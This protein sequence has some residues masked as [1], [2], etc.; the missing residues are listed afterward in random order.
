MDN[1]YRKYIKSVTNLINC[2]V[3]L[4]KK[5]ETDLYDTLL[6]KHAETGIEDPVLLMGE[7]EKIAEEFMENLGITNESSEDGPTAFWY[8]KNRMRNYPYTEY[9]SERKIFGIP[10][11]HINNKP[12]GV[13]KG[14]VAIGSISFGV[15]SLG[16]IAF[17]VLSFGGLGLGLIAAFGGG[18]V[19]GL[20]A[21]GGFALSLLWAIGGFAMSGYSAIGG[22]AQSGYFALGGYA[23]AGEIAVGGVANGN[24]AVY[25]QSGT[26]NYLFD[27]REMGM[28]EITFRIKHIMPDVS[29]FYINLIRNITPSIR[30]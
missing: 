30:F 17:G 28:E 7:P 25:N 22:Y 27:M 1:N 4:K 19:G 14:I 21:A 2:P 18:A 24:I 6:E 26:G 16:G 15:I 11:V 8:G 5:I 20:F 29:D 23:S 9:I 13:A 10:L 3:S 12:L